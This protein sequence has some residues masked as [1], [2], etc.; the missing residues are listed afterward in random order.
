MRLESIVNIFKE[1]KG[2]KITKALHE[3][4]WD[5]NEQY[6]LTYLKIIIQSVED[7][8]IQ[9]C[10]HISMQNKIIPNI[11]YEILEAIW[12]V[13]IELNDYF[14]F[15][16]CKLY[17]NLSGLCRGDS[18]KNL[19]EI[20][21]CPYDKYNLNC[22]F[23][24]ISLNI[25]KCKNSLKD[26]GADNPLLCFLID[27]EKT[28]SDNCNIALGCK[29]LIVLFGVGDFSPLVENGEY[30]YLI[31]IFEEIS[32]LFLRMCVQLNQYSL[33]FIQK[34][35]QDIFRKFYHDYKN[36][37]QR[38]YD[39]NN[40]YR[41]PKY[42]ERLSDKK[43]E[44]ICEDTNSALQTLNYISMNVSIL[45]DITNNKR[46]FEQ[47]CEIV[48]MRTEINKLRSL[49]RLELKKKKLCISIAGNFLIS[50]LNKDL[51]V[52][53]L[54]N[55]IN[56]AIKY[57]Y[58]GTN[59]CIDIAT[60]QIIVKN[61]GTD[62]ESGERPYELY[63]KVENVSFGDGIGLYASK[64]ISKKI[65]TELYHLCKKISNYNIPLVYEAIR[66]GLKFD[67]DTLDFDEAEKE[68]YQLNKKEIL[69]SDDYHNGEYSYISERT[70]RRDISKPTYHVS[71]IIKKINER[72]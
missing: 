57:S 72:L 59:I 63:Y 19:H 16:Y 46:K 70:I 30:K 12:D 64:I 1:E 13:I 21:S 48:D 54:Y 11:I 56:N 61:Y 5:N 42:Y 68:L 31:I 17:N 38:I 28:I 35:R 24:K 23:T 34:K 36:L 41:N 32:K 44:L 43:K 27:S 55:I 50:T 9:K 62:I 14:L 69:T 4:K 66:R 6:L 45:F 3:M 15:Q 58:Y 71:F 67:K 22:D 7:R 60:D 25:I 49:F 10:Y 2:N 52:L 39:N 33:A 40:Y 29:N 37:I 51:L 8:F 53:M 18:K 47:G 20:G 65:K 26:C